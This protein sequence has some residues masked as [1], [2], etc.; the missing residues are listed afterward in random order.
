MWNDKMNKIDKK[1]MKILYVINLIM[2]FLGGLIW[3]RIDF[4]NSLPFFAMAFTGVILLWLAKRITKV[5]KNVNK[6]ETT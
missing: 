2:F 6:R 3:G 5:Q 4:V 1:I